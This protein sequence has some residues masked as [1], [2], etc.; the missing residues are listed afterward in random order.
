MKKLDTGAKLSHIIIYVDK[1]VSE[2]DILAFCTNIKAKYPEMGFTYLCY[3]N[4]SQPNHG[5]DMVKLINSAKYAPDF[6]F[7]ITDSQDALSAAL[8]RGVACAALNTACNDSEDLYRARYCLEDI[9]FISY[10]RIRRIWQRHHTIPWTIAVTP[11]LEIREQTEEDLDSLY[12]IYDDDEAARFVEPLYMDRDKEAA[13]LRDY[14]SCQYGFHE[15]G[16]WAVTLKETGELIGRA[17]FFIREG[18][19]IPELGYII[20]RRHR[21]MGYAK[22]ALVAI[23]GYGLDELGF[24]RYMAFTDSRN[25][26]SVRLLESLGFFR[27]GSDVIMG[28]MHDRYILTLHQ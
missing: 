14:I 8:D 1:N 9:G 27:E 2:E 16:L 28:R 15:Y 6:L 7:I 11:R 23:T 26:A 17:G 4:Q 12:D 5:G 10:E 20:G 22:E 13:Y 18:Y 21:R 19:D 3:D 24:D 25:T